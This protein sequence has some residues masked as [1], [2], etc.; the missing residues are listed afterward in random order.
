[1]WQ[2]SDPRLVR[3]EGGFLVCLEVGRNGQKDT[4]CHLALSVWHSLPKER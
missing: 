1:M 4:V 2:T 3:S